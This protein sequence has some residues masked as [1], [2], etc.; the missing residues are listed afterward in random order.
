MTV[1][2][3]Y[4]DRLGLKDSNM[5][6]VSSNHYYYDEDEMRNTKTVVNLKELNRMGQVNDLLYSISRLLSGG[7]SFIGCFIDSKKQNRFSSKYHSL[8][9]VENGI[10]SKRPFMN[11]VYNKLDSVTN[12]YMTREDI[13]S[14]FQNYGFTIIDMTEID[15]IT[16]FHSL[17]TH[18]VK[19]TKGRRFGK[20]LFN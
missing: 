13:I 9:D 16:Y 15:G 12:N 10:V 14:L 1:V 5:I 19:V 7:S 17:K 2:L 20:K 18:S 11:R 4:I 6:V 8:N 3:N